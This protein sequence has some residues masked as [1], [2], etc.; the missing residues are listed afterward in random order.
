MVRVARSLMSLIAGARGKHACSWCIANCGSGQD[1]AALSGEVY[2]GRTSSARGSIVSEPVRN[3][4]SVGD[5]VEVETDRG[6]YEGGS[7]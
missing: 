2:E 6:R 5:R 3:W 4:R 7:R 1:R